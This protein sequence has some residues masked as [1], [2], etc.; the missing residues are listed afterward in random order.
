[1]PNR[2]RRTSLAEMADYMGHM[3]EGRTLHCSSCSLMENVSAARDF[4]KATGL[5]HMSGYQDDLNWLECSAFELQLM[6]MLAKRTTPAVIRRTVRQS[7]AGLAKT[8]SWMM[9]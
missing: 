3:L 8:L 7:M 4:I 5:R 9:N 6:N 2:C 1:M